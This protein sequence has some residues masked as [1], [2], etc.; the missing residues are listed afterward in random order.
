M[1]TLNE[2]QINKFRAI[3][4]AARRLGEQYAKGQGP[5]PQ[6]GSTFSGGVPM[7]TWGQ[8]LHE[9]GFKTQASGGS[10]LGFLNSFILGGTTDHSAKQLSR[11]VEEVKNG[12]FVDTK[13]TYDIEA[14]KKAAGDIMRA[15]DPAPTVEARKAAVAP[16]LKKLADT[17]EKEFGE[18]KEEDS[19]YFATAAEQYLENLIH[20][21]DD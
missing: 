14:I 18:Q 2:D 12:L 11:T 4:S 3:G 19:M 9:A 21:S 7:C 5:N 15:N 20:S 6:S 16:L 10:N 8:V 1:T 17:I 13:K